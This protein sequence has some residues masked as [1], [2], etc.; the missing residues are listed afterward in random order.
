MVGE[1]LSRLWAAR[2]G[3]SETELLESLGTLGSP[4]PRAQWSPLYLAAGDALVNKGGLLTFAHNFLREAVREAYLPTA[5]HR[6]N[7]H[8]SLA[9]YFEKRELTTRKVEEH[10][11]QLAESSQWRRLY[12]LMSDPN[13][14]QKAWE[15]NRFDVE[16]YWARIEQFSSLR[17]LDAY[18]AL[19]DQRVG[20]S[21]TF[22]AYSLYS[23]AGH[24]K[25]AQ[26]L[27]RLAF[28]H[29]HN[30]SDP[31]QG[32][33]VLPPG[34]EADF[35][36]AQGKLD[37][38]MLLYQEQERICRGFGNDMTLQIVLGGQ[39]GILLSKQEYDESLRLSK[40]QERVC[41]T[42]I[43]K[44]EQDLSCQG[45]IGLQRSLGHQAFIWEIRGE[46]EIALRLREG[47]ET[48]W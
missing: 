13:F 27:F 39:V 31:K 4:L 44:S 15:T 11:W 43:G 1:S 26:T 16:N 22:A 17:M 48:V 2:R 10:P 41:R 14:F 32:L 47:Q 3:F 21:G 8:L 37:E 25:E 23:D 33:R 46:L 40:E 19:T 18:P 36:V 38:A 30:S 9:D 12:D 6:R 34:L 7:A 35:L 29:L 20:W 42:L 45:K 5:E 28:D 24:E